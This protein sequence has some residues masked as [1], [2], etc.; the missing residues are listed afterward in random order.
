MELSVL[1]AMVVMMMRWLPVIPAI[2]GCW[3]KSV[4]VLICINWKR[5]RRNNAFCADRGNMQHSKSHFNCW[6]G[7]KISHFSSTHVEARH[8]GGR[9]LKRKH[10]LSQAIIQ[11]YF[12]KNNLLWSYDHWLTISFQCWLLAINAA[13]PA[14]SFP[15]SLPHNSHFIFCSLAVWSL[16][17]PLC[18][19][20]QLH[21]SPTSCS[22]GCST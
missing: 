7:K 21:L 1:E 6:W 16:I 11:P 4:R 17:V 15:F 13:P 22:N 5:S 3:L 2:L 19:T 14:W 12:K 10:F 8:W 20:N 9:N 18:S